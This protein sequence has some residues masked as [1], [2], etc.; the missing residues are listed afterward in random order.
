[1]GGLSPER[2]LRVSRAMH[3]GTH[4]VMTVA[5]TCMAMLRIRMAAWEMERKY[6]AQTCWD[7]HLD[8]GS[9]LRLIDVL[10]WKKEGLANAE[11]P[12]TLTKCW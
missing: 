6:C 12:L 8:M 10:E 3:R 9:G 5:H 1:M 7:D 4:Y 2:G 11:P